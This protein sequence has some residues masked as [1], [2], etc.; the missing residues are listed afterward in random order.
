[1][2]ILLAALCLLLIAFAGCTAKQGSV[3]TTSSIAT[4]GTKGPPSQKE[5]FDAIAEGTV[6]TGWQ[7]FGGAWA[8]KRNAT[9]TIHPKVMRAAGADPP[10]LSSLVSNAGDLTSFETFV[11]FKMVNGDAGAGVVVHWKDE[12]NH[13]ILRYSIRENSWHV[14]T[15]VD[16]NR[17]KQEEGTVA[18]A[19]THPALG[20]WVRMRVTSTSG[21]LVAY[22]GTTKVLEYT[23]KPEAET[24]GRVGLFV[25]G[26]AVVEFDDFEVEAP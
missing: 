26:T 15:M 13:Q 1:M 12:K 20:Q 16:G 2:R 8:A 4:T 6:P 7:T 11:S 9:D 21:H 24:T 23:L 14:F 25:R 19:S 5:N 10:G 17:V 3:P 18:G 22:D